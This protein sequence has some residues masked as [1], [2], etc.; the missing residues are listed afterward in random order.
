MSVLVTRAAGSDLNATVGFA[1]VTPLES[2]IARFTEWF[3]EY[4]R[5]ASRETGA[6][7]S[8]TA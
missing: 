8:V 1:P 2:G 6:R 5:G 3:L 7:S 4:A